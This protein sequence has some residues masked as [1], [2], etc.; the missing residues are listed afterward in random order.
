MELKIRKANEKEL[1]FL[2]GFAKDV[3]N[4]SYRSFLGDEAVDFF[5]GS[6]ASDQ[7]MLENIKDTT[8]ALMNNEIVGICICKENTIDLIM[9]NSEMHRKGIGS[10]FINKISEELLKSYD[11]IYLESFEKNLKANNFYYKNGWNKDK[12]MFDE[13]VGVNRIYYSK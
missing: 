12:V 7:Y 11:K 9:V 6:G 4:K 3:I 13:E 5:I 10:E 2:Q 1:V 8:V